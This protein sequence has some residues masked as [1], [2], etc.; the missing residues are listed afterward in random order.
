MCVLAL[1]IGASFIKGAR[2]HPHDGVIEHVVRKP[3][4]PF[5][6]GLPAGRREVRLGEILAATRAVLDEVLLEGPIPR[7]LL[8]CGQMHGLVLVSPEGSPLS[9]FSSWQDE[10]ALELTPDGSRTCFDLL[11]DRLGSDVLAALGNELRPGFPLAKLHAMAMHGRLPPHA[12]PLSL[13]DYVA[14][15]L[16]NR[17]DSPATDASNAAAH[18]ALHVARL[19]WH[20]DAI[21]RAGLAHLTWPRITPPAAPLGEFHYKGHEIRVHVPVGDQQAA[22]FGAELARD[23]VSLN[24]ATGSQVSI[25]A[26]GPE[27]GPWQVRPFFDQ[28][29]LRTVTHLPAGR[30]LNA[31]LGLLGEL[32]ADQGTPLRDPWAQIERLAGLAATPEMRANIAF[33]PSA[34]GDK[35]SLQGLSEGELHIGP[36]FRA[37]FRSMASNY[38]EAARRI[39]PAGWS[40]VVFSGG[41]ARRSGILREE[42]MAQFGSAHRVAVHTEDALAGLM[43]LAKRLT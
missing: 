37:V 21:E 8:I 7:A 17:L 29:W 42:I 23:E 34:V 25:V 43:H 35:G 12:V 10:R 38:L 22:L 4:P 31:L 1:D 39:A 2:V 26:A 40:R 9:E 33:F 27:A 5:C 3:F 19:E 16:C 28:C 11:V 15:S 20:T 41:L 30:A 24:I 13:P 32:A 14:L 6:E 36:L 18:G